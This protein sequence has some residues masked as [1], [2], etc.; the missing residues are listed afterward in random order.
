MSF[1]L[2]CHLQHFSGTWNAI[3]YI[4][5]ERKNLQVASYGF[6]T[7]FAACLRIARNYTET[8]PFH[9]ISTPGN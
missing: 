8:L 9:K 3:N 7:F 1:K 4:N 5:S 6:E 2:R